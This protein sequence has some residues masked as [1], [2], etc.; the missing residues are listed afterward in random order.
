MAQ[1]SK[2]DTFVGDAA[3]DDVFDFWAYRA[4]IATPDKVGNTLIIFKPNPAEVDLGAFESAA[5]TSRDP[6]LALQHVTLIL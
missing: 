4:S 1:I 6:S 2:E 5:I 3:L